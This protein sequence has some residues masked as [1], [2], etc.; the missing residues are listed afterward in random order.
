MP[1]IARLSTSQP[2]FDERLKALTA[3]DSTLDKEVEGRV[4]E[5]I[6]DVRA[7]GDDAVL[8][9]TGKYD[10]VSATNVQGLELPRATLKAALTGLP[11]TQREALAQASARVR[12]YHQKQLSKS[13]QYTEAD[14]TTLGQR[15]TPLDRVG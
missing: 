15:V 10:G 9:Y 5:I 8:H 2:D 4:S 3:I 12:K 1:E 11:S 7:R 13:W 6:A 14:G